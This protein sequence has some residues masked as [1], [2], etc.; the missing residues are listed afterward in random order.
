MN[1]GVKVVGGL[2]I[3]GLISYVIYL[4]T[5]E[6]GLRPPCGNYGDV[7]GDGYVR[8]ADVDL[9]TQFVAETVIPTPEQRL[10]ANV[11]GTEVL[12]SLSITL[13]ELYV[14]GT[15]TTFPVCA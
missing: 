10:R 4:A 14:A 2:A 5:Q 7:T 13:M 9:V 1:T 8:Q 11:A 12:N 3:A 6:N 15:I